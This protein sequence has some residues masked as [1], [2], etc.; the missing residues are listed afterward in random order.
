MLVTTIELWNVNDK[1]KRSQTHQIVIA[2]QGSTI[3]SPDETC[4]YVAYLFGPGW[5]VP[6][7]GP[8]KGDVSA[9]KAIGEVHVRHRPANGD[10]ELYFIVLREFRQEFP[11]LF[12]A[13]EPVEAMTPEM[14][15]AWR[16]GRMRRVIS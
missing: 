8:N 5:H 2:N 1:F 16:G 14:L 9:E 4:A 10:L 11:G 13:P 15:R 7:Q 12:E 6:T 3:R